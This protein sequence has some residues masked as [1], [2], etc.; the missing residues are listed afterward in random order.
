M[1]IKRFLHCS[2]CVSDYD[3][4]LAFYRDILGFN[5][6]DEAEWLSADAGK[7]MDVG[8]ASF[9]TALLRRDGQRLGWCRPHA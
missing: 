7:V 9:K 5:L 2:I 1:A 8:D 3:K 6:V 4:S